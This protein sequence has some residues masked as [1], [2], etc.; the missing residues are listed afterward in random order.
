MF[1]IINLKRLRTNKVKAGTL[2]L[3]LVVSIILY[4]ITISFLTIGL[5]NSNQNSKQEI[6][7][8]LNDNTNS[9]INLIFTQSSKNNQLDSSIRLFT[10]EPDSAFI[11]KFEWG[12]FEGC[13]L[14]VSRFQHKKQVSFLFGDV[15]DYLP[16]YSLYLT[17][18][19][20]ILSIAGE[21]NIGGKMSLP[22]Q[23]IRMAFM[24]QNS[25]KGFELK[26]E[27]LNESNESLPGIDTNYVKKIETLLQ[28]SHD[29]IRFK[30]NTNVGD[31]SNSFYFDPIYIFKKGH[32]RVDGIVSGNVI[33]I[34]DSSIFISSSADLSNCILIAPSVKFEDD[35]NGKVQVFASDSIIVGNNVFLKYPSSLV[36]YK[37]KLD[38]ETSFFK[39]GKYSTIRGIVVAF[40][41]SRKPVD[42]FAEFSGEGY[43]EGLIFINGFLDLRK[44]INGLLLVDYFIFREGPSVF[45]NYLK[46]VSIQRSEISSHFLSPPNLF[47]NSKK[48]IVEWL[49]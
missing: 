27:N 45:D 28:L 8:R 40:S 48:D 17:D 30:N 44:N 32:L 38:S 29:S 23:G 49:E 12:L 15:F 16:S 41:K 13:N 4:L 42:I 18:H 39:I 5:F 22:K 33:L 9:A 34:S 2:L 19:Q 37:N 46:D 20:R 35:F 24:D 11:K 10:D 47:S 31:I 3:T 21:T 25:A 36:L 1:L 14:I 7:S 43:I 26:N 6:L